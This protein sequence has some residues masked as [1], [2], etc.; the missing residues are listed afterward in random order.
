APALAEDKPGDAPAEK[1]A[2]K[3]AGGAETQD[4]LYALGLAIAV[5]LD[6]FELTESELTSVLAGLRDGVL[7]RP[8]K[9][10][11][12]DAFKA[13]IRDLARARSQGVLAREKKEGEAVLAKA[14]A[15]SG[16]A[17]LPTGVVYIEVKAGTGE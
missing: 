6:V 8:K 10:V 16:A 3:P 4:T 5:S 13:K 9:G 15:E 12:L 17:K 2:A 7:K 1:G 11:T 14:A